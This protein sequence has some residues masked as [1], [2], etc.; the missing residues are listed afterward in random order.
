MGNQV[1]RCSGLSVSGVRVQRID[2]PGEY[3]GRYY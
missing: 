2:H 1:L 3:P